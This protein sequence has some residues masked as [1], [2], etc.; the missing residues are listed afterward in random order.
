C[1][2]ASHDGSSRHPDIRGHPAPAC[3]TGSGG[4]AMPRRDKCRATDDVRDYLPALARWG[5]TAREAS[6]RPWP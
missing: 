3:G 5:V 1:Y 2:P 6:Y 4:R